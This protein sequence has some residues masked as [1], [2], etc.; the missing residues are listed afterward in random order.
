[1]N[2]NGFE[3][4]EGVP[5]AEGTVR[6]MSGESMPLVDGD[7]PAVIL[8]C[9][10]FPQGAIVKRKS[11]RGLPG[12]LRSTNIH[13][14]PSIVNRLVRLVEE[15]LERDDCLPDMDLAW[16]R[17]RL[18]EIKQEVDRA[19]EDTGKRSGSSPGAAQEERSA[20]PNH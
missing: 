19:E 3:W 11:E 5:L 10:Q 9:E 8:P 4:P 16:Y 1:M 7:G 17:N 2:I 15:L 13:N 20:D 14:E 6:P 12:R 18:V